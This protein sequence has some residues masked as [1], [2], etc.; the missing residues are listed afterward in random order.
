MTRAVRLVGGLLAVG[1]LAACAQVPHEGAVVE[2]QERQQPPPVEG[3]YNNPKGPQPGD[4]REAVVTGF[5]VAMTATPLQTTTAQ[6]FLSKEGQARWRPE[7]VVTYA[8]H[9]PARAEGGRVVVRLRGADQIGVAGQWQ[10]TVSGPGRRLVFPMVR[11]D[12]EWRID[13]VPNALIV[14]RSFFDQQYQTAQIYFYDPS[15]RILVPE[16]VHVPQGTQLASSL[17]NALVRGPGRSATGVSRTFLPPGLA[18]VLSVPVGENGVADVTLKGPDPGPLSR[19][20]TQLI[21]A[22]LTWTLRQD[23]SIRSFRLNIAGHQVTDSTGA[24]SFRVDDQTSERYDPAVSRASA[25]MYALRAGRLV[26]GPANRLTAINGPFGTDAVGI[27]PFSISLDG[28][29]VAAVAP[30]E[31]LV[32]PVQ[33]PGQ[34]MSVMTGEGLLRPTWDFAKRLWEVQNGTRGARVVYLAGGRVRPVHVPGVSGEEVRRFL[35]SRDGSRL[36]AVLRGPT[37]DRIVVSRLRYDADGRVTGASASRPIR[38]SS[39]GTRRIRDIGWTSPTTIAV[40]DRRS[41]AQAEVRIL[42]V[43]GSA[44]PSEVSPTQIT[45]TVRALATSPSDGETPFAVTTSGL[46]NISPAEANR[47]VSIDGLRHLTYAG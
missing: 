27:G 45:G 3:Q 34:P 14:P 47:P 43:D 22:Q 37:A 20:T 2:A 30:G 42:N 13:Q 33:D 10:G 28:S 38:W 16:P 36:V 26:S 5:F 17:V 18:P 39:S 8:D 4:S 24:Q 11:Q 46:I 21:L 15:G 9:T 12:D 25:Q 1:L 32:G 7:R 6:E 29:T 41:P 35:V 19:A 44:R 31:L 23:P 40:L